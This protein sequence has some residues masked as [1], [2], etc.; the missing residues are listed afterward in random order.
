MTYGDLFA[1]VSHMISDVSVGVVRT[2]DDN[3]RGRYVL[4]A[5]YRDRGVSECEH[6]GGH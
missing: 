2:E 6:G 3:L 4:I 1:G 5:C